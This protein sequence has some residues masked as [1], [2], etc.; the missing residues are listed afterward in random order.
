M[1]AKKWK[2]GRFFSPKMAPS[3]LN[4]DMQGI[5]I[6]DLHFQFFMLLN[7]VSN[8]QLN[9]NTFSCNSKVR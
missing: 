3:Q 9:T 7:E 1:L 8:V 2:W 5:N 6:M 4:S